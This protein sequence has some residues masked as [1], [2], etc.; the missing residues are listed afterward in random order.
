M[1]EGGRGSKVP[2]ILGR[3]VGQW[4]VDAMMSPPTGKT[5]MTSFLRGAKSR[6]HENPPSLDN[7]GVGAGP[8]IR[9]RPVYTHQDT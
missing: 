2:S 6:L 7:G 3:P 4:V 8:L 5:P 1:R 9:D